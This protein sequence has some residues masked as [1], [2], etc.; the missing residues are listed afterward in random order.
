ME[1][2]GKD[3]VYLE[4]SEYSN[5]T[6]CL[7]AFSVKDGFV[8]VLD[9]NFE[10][11]DLCGHNR[12]AVLDKNT[13]VFNFLIDNNVCDFKGAYAR[14]IRDDDGA[15]VDTWY[16]S[17]LDVIEENKYLSEEARLRKAHCGY[18]NKEFLRDALQFTEDRYGIS[19]KLA[20]INCYEEADAKLKEW[21]FDPGYAGESLEADDE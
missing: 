8:G 19:S 21:K 11:S 12:I 6:V 14:T 1:L 7:E 15:V 9:D 2:F 4:F 13:E 18:C 3:D 5:G 20:C 16:Y 17:I 10:C